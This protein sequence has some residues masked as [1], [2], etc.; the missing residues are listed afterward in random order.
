[1]LSA[2][3]LIGSY[4]YMKNYI[5]TI[6]IILL[7]LSCTESSNNL[8]PEPS[9]RM[10]PGDESALNDSVKNRLITD[11]YRLALR[12]LINNIPNGNNIVDIPDTLFHDFYNGLLHIYNYKSSIRDSIY[13]ML[14][15][16]SNPDP[17][18]HEIIII[19]DTSSTWLKNWLG[20]IFP[21]GN[22]K[23]DSMISKYSI[24]IFKDSGI[25]N[26]EHTLLLYSNQFNNIEA[27]NHQFRNIENIIN[28]SP[29][30]RGNYEGSLRD[31]TA[32]IIDDSIIYKYV[33]VDSDLFL[34]VNWFFKV[35]FTGNVTYLG[36]NL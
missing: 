4:V 6:L 33:V 3:G 11:G 32:N 7:T 9:K 17:V 24:Y 36:R 2:R 23:L 19:V 13:N 1:M 22:S 28:C 21:T 5:Y 35:D 26:N 31:V 10:F 30:Y 18:F 20:N 16:N 34:Y 27:L 29:N 15:V 8:L 12:H 25:Y 14:Y